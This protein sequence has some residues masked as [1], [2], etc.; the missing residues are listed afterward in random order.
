MTESISSL[1]RCV[2]SWITTKLVY[3]KLKHIGC[4]YHGKALPNSLLTGAQ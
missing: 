3:D 1:R 4:K 2:R